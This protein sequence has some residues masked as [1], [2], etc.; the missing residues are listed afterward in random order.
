MDTP[1]RSF[2]FGD[3]V[4]SR[5]SAIS[6]AA[7]SGGAAVAA[8]ASLILLS[9]GSGFGFASIS[10]W[11][12]ANPSITTVT[13]MTGIWLIVVQWLSSALGG[14]MAGRL[15]AT[16]VNLHTHEVFFRDTAHGLLA[17]AVA[18]VLV[19]VIVACGGGFAV[20]NGTRAIGTV[21]SGP[22]QGAVSAAGS[23]GE[24]DY[25]LDTLFRSERPDAVAPTADTRGEAARILALAAA[26]ND[27]PNADRAYLAGLVAVRTG[28]PQA[29]AEKRID[30]AVK[31]ANTAAIKARALA[32]ETRKA[33]SAFAIFTALSM[34]VGAF[35]SCVAAAIGGRLRD[36]HA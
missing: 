4:E 28:I 7:I 16:W 33:T 35:I 31:Q 12:N 2:S 21:A 13:V 3:A 18:T 14:Y 8:S 1:A 9:L 15:R 19:A 34:A 22:A 5:V 32:D 27:I 10:P 11:S 30:D 26:Y 17:W 23:D 25:T 29:D 6:W 24:S 20:S 36:E